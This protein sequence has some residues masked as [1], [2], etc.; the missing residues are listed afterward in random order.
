MKIVKTV[1]VIIFFIIAVTNIVF[2]AEQTNSKYTGFPDYVIFDET[3]CPEDSN[4]DPG[5]LEAFYYDGDGDGAGNPEDPTPAD[6]NS[7]PIYACSTTPPTGYVTNDFDIDDSN[8]YVCS[9]LDN[10]GCNDCSSGIF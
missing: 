4:G 6:G 9:D 5:T 3:E 7:Y 1:R 2:T 10:D 8:N